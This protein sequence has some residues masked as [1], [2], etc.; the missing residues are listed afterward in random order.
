LKGLATE[1]GG[2]D[3]DWVSEEPLVLTASDALTNSFR[4]TYT[5]THN[6]SRCCEFFL[7]RLADTK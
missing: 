7:S 5:I 3:C 2:Q 6:P 1:G 4:V